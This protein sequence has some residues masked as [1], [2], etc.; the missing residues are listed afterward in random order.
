MRYQ[1]LLPIGTVLL[2]YRRR[3]R[4]QRATPEIRFREENQ[5]NE[6][7]GPYGPTATPWSGPPLLRP[8][9]NGPGAI[10]PNGDNIADQLNRAELSRLLGGGRGPAS[11][12]LSRLRPPVWS[13]YA[14]FRR[15]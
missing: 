1:P 15:Q 7:K 5:L 13:G 12:G 14:H 3:R 4:L 6:H 9:P 2:L 10:G 8:A 11:S